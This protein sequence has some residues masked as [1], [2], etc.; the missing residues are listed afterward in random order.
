M[1]VASPE[2][3]ATQYGS[4]C[5]WALSHGYTSSTDP[6]PWRIVDGKLYLNYSKPV[7]S[8]WNQNIV[9]HI[10]NGDCNWPKIRIKLALNR[11]K[12]VPRCAD[13]RAVNAL[14][15]RPC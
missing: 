5:T 15:S 10:A 7:Q 9:G 14:V 1:F 12:A 13:S 3:Y 6:Q 8:Q 4:W 11:R 2:E